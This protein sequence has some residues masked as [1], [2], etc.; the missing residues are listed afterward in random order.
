MVALVHFPSRLKLL[1]IVQAGGGLANGFGLG[2]GRQEQRCQDGNDGNDHQEF[3]KREG[4]VRAHGH[5]R[6]VELVARMHG[7]THWFGLRDEV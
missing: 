5:R 3:D 2:H 4:A 7:S 6:C 1:Q